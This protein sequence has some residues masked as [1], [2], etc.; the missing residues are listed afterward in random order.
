[1][2]VWKYPSH[3][4]CEMFLISDNF[5]NFGVSWSLL[6]ANLAMRSDPEVWG[7]CFDI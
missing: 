5:D 2:R 3:W 7:T 1:M 4:C 6:V